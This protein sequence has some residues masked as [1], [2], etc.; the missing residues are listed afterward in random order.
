MTEIKASGYDFETEQLEVYRRFANY[1]SSISSKIYFDAK[2]E[3]NID[4]IIRKL[5]ICYKNSILEEYVQNTSKIISPFVD[6]GYKYFPKELFPVFV[7]G[8]FVKLV[9]TSSPEQKRIIL[10]HL[11]ERLDLKGKMANPK[12]DEL[13]F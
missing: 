11:W 7:L 12:N 1:L 5:E 4:E 6:G 2:Y 8:D 9:K 10:N 3:T 13:P